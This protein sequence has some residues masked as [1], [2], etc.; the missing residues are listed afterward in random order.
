MF[1]EVYVVKFELAPL[2]IGI[3]I[4]SS[5]AVECSRRKVLN[6]LQKKYNI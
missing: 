6:Y 2:G 3:G 1:S 4:V 5:F